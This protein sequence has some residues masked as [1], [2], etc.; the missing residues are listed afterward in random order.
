M[1]C[2]HIFAT[3]FGFCAIAWS[4]QG[5][6]RFQLPECDK[7]S[8]MD[9]MG[10]ASQERQD[11]LPRRIEVVV[12]KVER[13]FNGER[14]EFSDAPLDLRARRP[15]DMAVYEATRAVAWGEI[16][17]YGEIA[18]KA[19]S[20]LAARAVGHALS[21]NPI[22]IIIPCHRILAAG[23]KIGGFSAFGGVAVKEQLLGLEGAR[24]RAA[25]PARSLFASS[26]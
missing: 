15:F 25:A 19:G 23:A 7:Q 21:R 2:Y 20:P 1:E 5:V 13:Y 22:A 12:A 8:L 24:R 16:A 10:S 9:R 17:T 26:L 18:R 14:V 11:D 4:E 3:P 6:T